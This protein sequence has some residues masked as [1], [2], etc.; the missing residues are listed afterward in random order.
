MKPLM[1]TGQRFPHATFI[2]TLGLHLM[3]SHNLIDHV[4]IDKRRL[5]NMLDVRPFRGADCDTNH[6]L[7]AA[8]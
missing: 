1:I 7:V 8:N 3:V 6:Y 2:N 4:L 5:S